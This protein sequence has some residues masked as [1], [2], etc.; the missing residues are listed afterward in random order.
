M[1]TPPEAPPSWTHD[2]ADETGPS[3]W[4]SLESYQLCAEGTSQSPIDL[5]GAVPGSLPPLEFDYGAEPLIVEN[6]GHTVEV[7]SQE[8]PEETL[9][10]GDDVYSLDQYHFHVPSEHTVGGRRYDMEAHL[11]HADARGRI[12]VVAVFLDERKP[13][14]PLVDEV[15]GSAP[16]EVGERSEPGRQASAAALLPTTS[17]GGPS[18]IAR[19]TTYS[20]SLTTPGCSED[21][22]WIVLADPLGVASASTERMREFVSGLPGYDGYER[23]NRPTQPLNGRRIVT[24]GDG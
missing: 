11:V 12:A 1:A 7:P 23:N 19:Y 18:T 6:T 20:G 4:G 13:P 10:I 2:P 24:T 9:T 8:A 22:R 5:G 17:G 15:I 21:V 16:E 14:S 3:K